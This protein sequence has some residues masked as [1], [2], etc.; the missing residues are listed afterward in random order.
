MLQ[1]TEELKDQAAYDD[2]FFVEKMV[3]WRETDEGVLQLKV[4]W[5]G[6]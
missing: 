4:R 6:I 2:Q 5:L 1:I 3:D